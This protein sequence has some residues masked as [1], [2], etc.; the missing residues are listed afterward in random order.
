ME[1]YCPDT[2]T[3]ALCLS[4][5]AP[6][7]GRNCDEGG[8]TFRDT[9]RTLEAELRMDNRRMIHVLWCGIALWRDGSG[10]A[11]FYFLEGERN[12]PGKPRLLESNMF[13]SGRNEC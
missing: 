3:L 6:L 2:P 13:D 1:L 4:L 9:A 8:Q 12:L 7:F 10:S 11:A 5:H